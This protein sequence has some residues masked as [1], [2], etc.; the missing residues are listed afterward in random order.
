[1]HVV[2]RSSV[3]VMDV[4][5]KGEVRREKARKEVMSVFVHDGRFLTTGTKER[6]KDVFTGMQ[7]LEHVFACVI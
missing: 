7:Q 1:M 2:T 4:F 3:V 6:T 5:I